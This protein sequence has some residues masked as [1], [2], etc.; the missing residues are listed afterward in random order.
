MELSALLE[1]SIWPLSDFDSSENA[2]LSFARKRDEISLDIL[3][4]RAI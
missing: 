1:P 4:K 2:L 3:S